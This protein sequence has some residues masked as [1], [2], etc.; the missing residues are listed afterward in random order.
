[1]AKNSFKNALNL[2]SEDEN[3]KAMANGWLKK[4][5]SE[6]IAPATRKEIDGYLQKGEHYICGN[7]PSSAIDAFQEVIKINEDE[8]KAYYG[9]GSASAASGNTTEALKN[10]Q[11]AIECDPTMKEALCETA[12]LYLEENNYDKAIKNLGKAILID[13]LYPDAHYL[14]GLLYYKA[15]K[16]DDAGR[17]FNI[18]LKLAPLGKYVDKTKEMMNNL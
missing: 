18:Y 13:P 12:S 11:K 8:A 2:P 4:L 15:D 3:I 17:E 7:M 14:S 9:F 10:F 5:K 6:N 16:K 1:M